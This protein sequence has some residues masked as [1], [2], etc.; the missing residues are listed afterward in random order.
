MYTEAAP[1]KLRKSTSTASFRTQQRDSDASELPNPNLMRTAADGDG[2]YDRKP[3]GS[4]ATRDRRT[5]DRSTLKTSSAI[6]P[7]RRDVSSD[8]LNF[9]AHGKNNMFDLGPGMRCGTFNGFLY[10][11]GKK[12]AIPAEH[13]NI[14]FGSQ[15]V[16]NGMPFEDIP[17]I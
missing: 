5:P 17:V 13:L 1:A 3:K 12:T 15:I 2:Y 16:I 4:K 11:N 10:K 7:D 8:N 6:N 14:D 9:Q